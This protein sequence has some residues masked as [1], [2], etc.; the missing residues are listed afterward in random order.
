M[1]EKDTR[2]SWIVTDLSAF[3]PQR[4]YNQVATGESKLQEPEPV[5]PNVGT[6]KYFRT[7]SIDSERIKAECNGLYDE[8][9]T[10]LN[11]FF[12]KPGLGGSELEKELA[13]ISLSSIGL[14]EELR[15]IVDKAIYGISRL[16]PI[17]KPKPEI[18]QEDREPKLAQAQR[19]REVPTV[20]V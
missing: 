18:K 6:L 7:N 15:L 12:Q 2:P 16:D 1:L 9:V 10:T 8:L 13:Q 11:R 20:Y 3:D 19:R 4:E 5:M 17:A 14:P